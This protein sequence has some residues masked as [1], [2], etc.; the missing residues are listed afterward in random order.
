MKTK[1]FIV[2]A[3][4]AA[5]AAVTASSARAIEPLLSPRASEN[6]T[7]TVPG[8]TEDKLARGLV[9]GS[10]KGLDQK[11][12]KVAGLNKDRDWV[13]ASKARLANPHA[14]D[15]FPALAKS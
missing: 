6:Q 3:T 1:N 5:S 8:I 14:L 4:L 7:R 2:F 10:P 11:A 15:A 13:H 12:A 9:I